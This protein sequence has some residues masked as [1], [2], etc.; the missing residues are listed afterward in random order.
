MESSRRVS[1]LPRLVV[2]VGVGGWLAV[3]LMGCVWTVRLASSRSS[4]D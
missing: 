4:K 1:L 2:F 3:V